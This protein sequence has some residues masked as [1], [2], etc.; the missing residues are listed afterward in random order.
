MPLQYSV[1]Q[2][3]QKLKSYLADH[4]S[5]EEQK[6]L[7][8]ALEDIKQ[9][10]SNFRKDGSPYYLHPMRIALKICEYGFEGK[11]VI[12][13]LLHDLLE[14]TPVDEKRLFERY[15]QWYVQVI[16]GL[17]KVKEAQ[18][19][20]THRKL[21]YTST[22]YSPNIF[23]IKL[24]DRWDNLTDMKLI[25]A[26]KRRR[27]GKES[28]DGYL[29]IIRDL[30]LETMANEYEKSLLRYM[31]PKAFT[32]LEKQLTTLRKEQAHQIWQLTQSLKTFMMNEGIE[33]KVLIQWFQPS[34]FLGDKEIS[35]GSPSRHAKQVLK[36]LRIIVNSK[37]ICYRVLGIVHLNFQVS[38]RQARDYIANPLYNGYCRLQTEIIHHFNPVAVEIA[39][40]HSNELSRK[41]IIAYWQSNKDP[42]FYQNYLTELESLL[43]SD[44]KYF[45]LRITEL[46]KQSQQGRIQVFVGKERQNFYLPQNAT[47]LDLAYYVSEESGHYCA[48]GL[49]QRFGTQRQ[50]PR[51]FHLQDDDW[52]EILKSENLL[53][54]ESWRVH[55]IT[56]YA[57][58]LLEKKLKEKVL[59]EAEQ[60][61]KTLFDSILNEHGKDSEQVRQS[62][63]F[64]EVLENKRWNIEEFF[65]KIGLGHLRI[66]TFLY[67]HQILNKKKAFLA[68]FLS[69]SFKETI[70]VENLS[71]SS[72]NFSECCKVLPNDACLGVRYQNLYELELHRK[73]CK[74][75]SQVEA[76]IVIR[77]KL[78][79]RQFAE[80]E[81]ILIHSKKHDILYKIWSV[82]K[83]VQCNYLKYSALSDEE[84]KIALQIENISQT[85]FINIL[86]KFRRI[87]AVK[88]FSVSW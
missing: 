83:D 39:D 17:S 3:E 45:D 64:Q 20:E 56:Q 63:L 6:L 71:C 2:I 68:P 51:G 85:A 18:L 49:L 23:F 40:H 58:S 7:D 9:Y 76:P 77:W 73:N 31:C 38:P 69:R 67:E 24:F 19:S 16:D 36:G 47:V 78:E 27:I 44:K 50:V 28:R 80:K 43:V 79:E 30:G 75:V 22:K 12:A 72:I 74:T 25:R 8:Y 26:S 46:S 48:G 29:P 35:G 37:P 61:G 21:L 86:K 15:G 65:Q 11:V 87:K 42:S 32:H 4:S 62:L 55:I 10:H 70:A 81:I 1:A 60:L 88:R 34:D 33:A 52:I 13:A 59:L 53:I 41:G 57:K 5:A 14:D 82:L 54:N 66:S 84:M